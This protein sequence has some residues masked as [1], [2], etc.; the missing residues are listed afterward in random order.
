MKRTMLAILCLLLA[1]CGGPI[2]KVNADKTHSSKWK[3]THRGLTGGAATTGEF[4]LTTQGKKFYLH[5]KVLSADLGVWTIHESDVVY[6]GEKL[7]EFNR[8]SALKDNPGE[9]FKEEGFIEYTPDP[10]FLKNNLFWKIPK[11]LPTAED[12]TEA[13]EGVTCNRLISR[14][15]SALGGEVVFRFWIDPNRNLLLRRAD[16]VGEDSG[17][18]KDAVLGS[19]FTCTEVNLSP[20]V[21]E[22]KFSA[23]PEGEPE[24]VMAYQWI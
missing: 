16:A 10:D 7:R 14:Q 3:V 5:K 4:E 18:G 17:G 6:D 19:D 15:Q 1:G 11:S 13:V 20:S 23:A 24:K 21:D 22:S 12:G 2:A 9:V 8:T